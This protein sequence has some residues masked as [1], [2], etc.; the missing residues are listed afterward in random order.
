MLLHV[1]EDATAA[2]RIQAK[3][4]FN[5]YA[6]NLCHSLIIDKLASAAHK[7]R[8]PPVLRNS[9]DSRYTQYVSLSHSQFHSATSNLEGSPVTPLKR[10]KTSFSFRSSL[11]G[12][13]QA[14]DALDSATCFRRGRQGSQSAVHDKS[15][16]SCQPIRQGAL[17][18]PPKHSGQRISTY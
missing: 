17:P 2:L 9:R 15:S 12:R 7:D 1:A 5:S 16:A 14:R 13:I 18:I 11:F 3:K 8:F 6:H 4:P 10:G